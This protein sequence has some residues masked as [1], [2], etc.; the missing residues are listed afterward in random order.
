M[1]PA[2]FRYWL[3]RGGQRR[4]TAGP[5]GTCACGAVPTTKPPTLV[6]DD[7]STVSVSGSR[8][9][10]PRN[11]LASATGS[12]QPIKGHEAYCA[13]PRKVSNDVLRQLHWDWCSFFAA[14][15]A[16][17]AGASRFLGRPRLHGYKDK[18]RAA[19]CSSVI[20]SQL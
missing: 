2:P 20:F 8:D 17:R 14:L 5:T 4:S 16:W 18:Q 10:R 7:H 12:G 6:E 11:P 13:M 9:E 19:I 1:A 15:E 3:F